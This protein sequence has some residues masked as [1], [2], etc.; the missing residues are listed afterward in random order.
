MEDTFDFM[1]PRITSVIPS[2]A[3]SN[4]KI[5]VEGWFFGTQR[6][7]GGAEVY[8]GDEKC[9]IRYWTMDPKNGKSIMVF[10]V[11]GGFSPGDYDVTVS[12]RIGLHRI[13]CALVIH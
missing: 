2:L 8:L 10:Q 12:N 1:C 9:R 6:W 11:P 7:L 13:R 4:D 3:S 5:T